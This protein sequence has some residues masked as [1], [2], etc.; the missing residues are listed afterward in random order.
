MTQ[1]AFEI[2][3]CVVNKLKLCAHPVPAQSVP[4]GWRLVP[5][6]PTQEMLGA[7]SW[8]NCAATDYKAMLAAAPEMNEIN[9]GGHVE[10]ATAEQ[11]SRQKQAR[12]ERLE[13]AVKELRDSLFGLTEYA[14]TSDERQYGTLAASFVRNV[15]L[16]ALKNTEGV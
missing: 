3:F 6:E 2:A 13:A 12:I 4:E 15:A 9:N 10:D 8:P 11:D 7:T 5:I 16:E 14:A 1:M